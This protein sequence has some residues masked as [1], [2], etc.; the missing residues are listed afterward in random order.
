LGIIGRQTIKSTIYIY[1][2]AVI[3][4][5]VRAHLFPEFLTP[6]QIGVLALL[7][8]YGSIYAQVAMLGFDHATIRYFP[9]FRDQSG[10]GGF[11]SLY[12]IIA[13]IG[14]LISWLVLE[15]VGILAIDQ[16][17]DFADYYY[18]CVP[19]TLALLF[20][21]VLDKYNTV[22]YNA[23]TG[24]LLREFVHRIL[25]LLI[26]IP[27]I[28]GVVSFNQFTQFYIGAFL[29]MAVL[30]AAF[31]M[32]RGEFYLDLNFRSVE[33][34]MI[35]AM[36]GISVFGFAT[37]LTNVVNL[38]IN[39]IMIDWF[40]DESHTGIYITNFFFATLILIPSRGL[41]KIAPTM[42]SDAFKDRRIDQIANIQAKS[43]INQQLIAVLV[44]IGLCINLPNI[45][46][47]L[48]E[49]YAEGK[50][51]IVYTGLANV[52]QMTAG[53]STAIIGFS[54]YYRYN[55]YLSIA[56]LLLLVLLNLA[57]L[58][59]LNISGAAI[60]T[61]ISILILNLIRFII[62]KNKFNIQPYQKRHLWI[63]CIGLICL[64]LNQ[65]I[66][67]QDN[68][69]MDI[70]LR[71]SVITVLFVLP[72]YFLITSQQ[73]NDNLNKILEVLRIRQ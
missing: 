70:L 69:I 28:Y 47:I 53:V 67:V 34:G 44:F 72:N 15:L 16:Q 71:S 24:V 61:L 30:M 63:I 17:S 41:S 58:P 31:V 29:F 14:F 9:Y 54:S 20:F 60:A 4:F 46:Q 52:I 40:Y 55:T 45:Y 56:Q 51:V 8:S 3:G 39:N 12:L 50:W 36:A 33:S 19:L 7:V 48:P 23:S 59:V 18:L 13:F 11:L 68:Y 62:L 57:L 6:A 66:P 43:T 5:Y 10:H 64:G 25:V 42:I 38:Q 37:G 73:L 1:V 35:R 27:L 49:T 26:L 32:L 2:G 21:N 22:L 65:L